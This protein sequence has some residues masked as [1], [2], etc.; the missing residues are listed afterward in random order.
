MLLKNMKTGKKYV[1][2]N[3]CTIR[4]AKLVEGVGKLGTQE[5]ETVSVRVRVSC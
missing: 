4:E 1:N 2:E 3:K 5:A